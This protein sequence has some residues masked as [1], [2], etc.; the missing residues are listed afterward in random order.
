MQQI[1]NI[2]KL[3]FKPTKIRSKKMTEEE[4]KN[5]VFEWKKRINIPEDLKHIYMD[6]NNCVIKSNTDDH[7]LRF[8]DKVYSCNKKFHIPSGEIGLTT[9]DEIEHCFV[10]MWDFPKGDFPLEL[11]KKGKHDVA[12]IKFKDKFEDVYELP[13]FFKNIHP[14]VGITSDV[15]FP[16]ISGKG[17]QLRVID[18]SIWDIEKSSIYS[19]DAFNIDLLYY[20]Y[21]VYLDQTLFM[22]RVMNESAM[23]IIENENTTQEYSAFAGFDE[24]GE[25]LYLQI[26]R[27]STIGRIE[28]IYTYR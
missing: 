18:K 21:E 13:L 28:E 17:S 8:M 12:V 7:T 14:K 20:K 16:T 22:F 1:Y 4:E 25:I 9:T 11:G 15:L 26:K 6:K 19:K 5:K 24:S 3:I 10:I 23:D 2:T 27:F